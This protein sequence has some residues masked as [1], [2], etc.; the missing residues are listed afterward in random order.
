MSG[1][2]FGCFCCLEKKIH[3]NYLLKKEKKQLKLV[4]RFRKEK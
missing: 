3:Q 2:C 4:E 1:C